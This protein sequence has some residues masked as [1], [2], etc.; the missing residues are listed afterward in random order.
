MGR[1]ILRELIETDTTH[2]HG[3]TTKAA[4]AMARRLLAAG[5]PAADVQVIAPKESPNANLVARLRGS[6]QRRPI[7]LLAHLDV[8]EARKE[9]WSLDPFTLTEKDGYFYGRGA[10]DIKDGA[11]I[12][13]A[14]LVRLKQEQLVPDRDIVVALTAGE[15]SGGDYNGLSW[16]L[17]EHRDLIDAAYCINMDAGDPQIQ[18]G[19]RIARTVQA[20][21]KV[22]LS[23]ALEATSPGGHSSMPKP[24]NPIYRLAAGLGRLAAHS[25]PV[26][27]NEVSRAYLE[28]MA[29]LVADAG[30]AADLRAVA[31]TPSDASAA[32]RLSA[33]A[34]YNAQL[35][36]TCVA[37]EIEGGHAENALPQRARAIV[38]CRM[39]PDEAPA[40]V[41]A[42][43]RRVVAD[44]QIHVSVFSPA[45]PGPTSPLAPEVMEPI[46]RVTAKLWPG[47][48]VIPVMETGATD[49]KFLRAAGIPTYGVSGVFIDVDDDRAHGRDERIG[50]R[51]FY[52][53]LEYIHALVVA[54]TRPGGA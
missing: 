16:L 45:D 1:D 28:R 7:L 54:L 44:E 36:T 37:T 20:S 42:T 47:V 38:N 48:P 30:V 8:V 14:T 4:E 46:E 50:V 19:K 41:E 2:E 10:Y 15:E 27:L 43:A 26:R 29:P 9:D 6:G 13:I 51:D 40:E 18:D 35:R 34:W 31:A 39:L 49:G 52:D 23:L 17:K 53:G 21:E 24:D 12:L 32:S 5:L 11:A 22:V 33:S 25:F 3:T